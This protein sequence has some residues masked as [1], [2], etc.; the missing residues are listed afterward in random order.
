MKKPINRQATHVDRK[1]TKPVTY[2]FNSFFA[3]IGGFDLGFQRAGC[4][5]VFHCEIN[6]Y[7]RSVL[8]RHWPDIE[9]ASDIKDVLAPKLPEAEIWCG[10]FP[11]QDV[12][13]ARGAKGRE[14]LNGR[15]TGLFYPFIELIR[16]IRP[17]V[18]ILENVMG[19]LNSHQGRDFLTVVGHLTDL[20]YGVSWR[21]FNTRYFGAPQ[22][23]PRVFICAWQGN[24]D[25]AVAALYEP[26]GSHK[27]PSPRGGFLKP[28][29][30]NITGAIVPEISYCLAATSGRHTGTDWS[31]SYVSYYDKVRRPT[32]AECEGLQ[33][34]PLGWTVPSAKSGL[35]LDEIDTLRYHAL[36]NA[37]STPVVEWIAKRIVAILDGRTGL[38][39]AQDI[40]G[41]IK[42]DVL[43]TMFDEFRLPSARVQKLSALR[44]QTG[45][46]DFAVKW[47]NGGYA[48]KDIVIDSPVSP[49]PYSPIKSL[50]VDVVEK[51][52]VAN[53][54]FL[55]TNAAQGIL[56]RVDSQGRVLFAPLHAALSRLAGVDRSKIPRRKKNAGAESSSVIAIA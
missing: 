42:G 49:A 20:G 33:G 52:S 31:R 37:V 11:C 3:G 27:P 34:F 2:R 5:P 32:P 50:F 53:H 4:A 15:N 7:C 23:R 28:Y 29:E 43:G 40:T 25:A 44:T 41:G 17:R 12:S 8:E 19:L 55:S 56:R 14:G 6:S 9:T 38:A 54:Y 51:Q 10:G 13:V 47:K 45:A 39:N 21:V 48:Y 16:E 24:V 22:S 30:C 1:K 35:S 26:E 46:S 36:G 18:V